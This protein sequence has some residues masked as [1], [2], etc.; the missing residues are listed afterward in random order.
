VNKTK[1]NRKDQNQNQAKRENISGTL[2]LASVLY[3]FLIVIA[4]YAAKATDHKRT[5]SP[6]HRI[7]SR[8]TVLTIEFV[9]QK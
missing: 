2:Q 6:G 5:S 7:W 1:D 8:V 9:Y 3:S 4:S